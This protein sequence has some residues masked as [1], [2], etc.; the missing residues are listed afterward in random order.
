MTTV[1]D[2]NQ[3]KYEDTGKGP[4][5]VIVQTDELELPF[6]QVQA[7]L[8]VKKG[9]RVIRFLFAEE[10]PEK[11]VAGLMNYMGLGRA[12]IVSLTNNADLLKAISTQYPSR[13]AA[14]CLISPKEQSKSLL[15]IHHDLTDMPQHVLIGEQEHLAMQMIDHT[16]MSRDR[17][18]THPV[19]SHTDSGWSLNETEISRLLLKFLRELHTCCPRHLRWTVWSDPRITPVAG[20]YHSAA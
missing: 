1:I 15:R 6:W 5:V 9:F 2:G 7:D 13:I 10:M 14:T 18:V 3:V 16:L 12:V 19:G 17:Q 8:L 4:A 20:R 11:I